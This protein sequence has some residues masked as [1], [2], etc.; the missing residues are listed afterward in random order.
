MNVRHETHRSRRILTQA[1][2]ALESRRLL[3]FGN[4]DPSFGTGGKVLTDFSGGS[5]NGYAMTVSGGKTL[6]AG[7]LHGDFVVA[8]YNANGSLDTT[9]GPAHTGYATVDF[10]SDADE[11]YA[12]AIGPDGKIVLA[13]QTNR[14]ATF[15]DFAVARLNADGSLDSTFG[16][17]HT[18]KF[19][20]DF[21]GDF[22]QA[23]GVAVQ[24]NGAVVVSR[25]ATVDFNAEF[26]LL[27][28]TSAGALDTS[29][30]AA[31]TGKILTE[32]TDAYAESTNMGLQAD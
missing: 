5:S 20:A 9:F 12:I 10:G 21:A 6:V 7:T 19:C 4:L 32:W 22:D 3:S 8:R 26:A 27:R 15:Y 24:S 30:G 28:L 18:G 14:G 31:H 29:F 17:A 23:T 1:V 2:E 11:A 16:A 13:G 25:M